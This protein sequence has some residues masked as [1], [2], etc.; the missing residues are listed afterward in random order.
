MSSTAPTKSILLAT[1]S[2]RL[3]CLPRDGPAQLPTCNGNLVSD[4]RSDDFRQGQQALEDERGHLTIKE[5]G[6]GSRCKSDWATAG[7][8]GCDN[9]D[10]R[11]G[12]RSNGERNAA[13]IGSAHGQGRSRLPSVST[14]GLAV[15][16]SS[17]EGK[18]A[19][20]WCVGLRTVCERVRLGREMCRSS[21]YTGKKKA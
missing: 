12:A 9:A 21:A 6:N 2:A 15:V 8:D 10:G 19:A 11:A 7:G 17:N 18:G 20:T 4:G 13:T 1:C 14:R 5:V 16:L 3:P